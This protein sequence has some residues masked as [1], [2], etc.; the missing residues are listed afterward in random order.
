MFKPQHIVG[1]LF[2]T[3]VLCGHNVA[4]AE[5][6]VPPAQQKQTELDQ[7]I[8]SMKKEVLDLNRDLL[9][10]E[11]ELLFPANT[12]FSVF[13]SMDVGDLFNLDSVQLRLDDKIVTNHLYTEREVAALRRGGVHRLYLGNLASGKHELVAYFTGQGPEHRDYRRGT[14]VVVTKDALPQFVELKIVDNAS[15]QQPDFNVKIWK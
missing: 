5:S 13:L 15:S 11:E 2:L 9:L 6:A 10:L 7:N 14:T 4:A 8:Q 12:Q 1:L 3:F